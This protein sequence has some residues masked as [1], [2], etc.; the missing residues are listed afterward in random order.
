MNQCGFIWAS[1]NCHTWRVF[2]AIHPLLIRNRK[3]LS[4]M[5]QLGSYILNSTFQ[6]NRL[7]WP[8]LFQLKWFLSLFDILYIYIFHFIDNEVKMKS[9]FSILW[10]HKVWFKMLFWFRCTSHLCKIIK[11]NQLQLLNA[12][13]YRYKLIII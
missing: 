12:V 8:Y 6:P 4:L 3:S 13:I 5:N 9:H 10:N 1:D 7:F 11:I 2:P